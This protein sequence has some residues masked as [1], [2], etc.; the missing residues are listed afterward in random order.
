MWEN[1]KQ[2]KGKERREGEGGRKVHLLRNGGVGLKPTKDNLLSP[3]VSPRIPEQVSLCLLLQDGE[4]LRGVCPTQGRRGS[5]VWG[6]A[7]GRPALTQR[8]WARP[9]PP[10]L[11]LDSIGA[12]CTMTQISSHCPAK[13]EGWMSVAAL[14]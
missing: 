13:P 2:S 14:G 4:L 9:A 11:Y 10:C 12:H 3:P 5:Q 7:S 1:R 8:G 6:T